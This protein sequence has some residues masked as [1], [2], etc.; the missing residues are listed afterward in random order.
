MKHNGGQL[1]LH[2]L[3]V[4]QLPETMTAGLGGL[5]AN[6]NAVRDDT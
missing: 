1:E 3:Y 4:F 5:A 6:I 2:L